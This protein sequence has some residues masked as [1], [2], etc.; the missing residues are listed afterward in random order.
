M[1]RTPLAALALSTALIATPFLA[2]PAAAFDPASMS[3]T[4]QAA[5][6]DAVR[7][8]LMANPEV[9]VEAIGVLETRQQAAEAGNDKVLV[10]AN[11]ADIFD[12]ANSWVG[13]NPDGDITVVEFLDY[14]CT[15]CRKATS[16]VDTLINT[17]GNIRFVIKEFPILGQES[18]LSS[19]F[20]IAV[21]QLAGDDAYKAAHD[22]LMEFRG[23]ITLDSL[24][25]LAKDLG[26]DPAPIMLRMNEDSVSDVLRANRQLGERMRISGTPAFVMGGQMLRGY[27]PVDGLRQIVAEERG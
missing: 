14:R 25:R 12:D 24:S 27:L 7:D 20:A 10:Q 5:F 17:D 11:A 2:G 16:E 23:A 26:Q 18:E 9:L 4:D 13:G 1:T 19:R 15:Y 8:Y 22:A 6:G 3:K 21:K